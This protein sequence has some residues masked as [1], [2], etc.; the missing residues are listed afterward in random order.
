MVNIVGHAANEV[1]AHPVVGIDGVAQ[2]SGAVIGGACR[3]AHI[4][5]GPVESDDVGR[6]GDAIRRAVV[7]VT[8]AD[9]VVRGVLSDRNARSE[10]PILGTSR[11]GAN[12]VPLDAVSL[13]QARVDTAD[14]AGGACNDI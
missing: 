9:E 11:A 1:D 13:R 12:A 5:A 14:A 2:H 8:A 6:R 10:S 7:F 3:L 4:D